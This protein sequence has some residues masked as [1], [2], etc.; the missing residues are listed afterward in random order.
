[1]QPLL[2]VLEQFLRGALNEGI[3]VGQ[4]R[5]LFRPDPPRTV[6]TKLNRGQP[7][8]HGLPPGQLRQ[9]GEAL[10]LRLGQALSGEAGQGG[11]FPPA[12]AN[13]HQQALSRH[14]H[15]A[16]KGQGLGKGQLVAIEGEC[17]QGFR[18]YLEK[19][20]RRFSLNA[21]RPS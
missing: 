13:A 5:R 10:G 14:L 1:M 20:G 21:L 3:G 11:Y 7:G 9:A 17:H 2:P 16:V 4:C 12:V 6:Q 15:L 19:S 18:L 8:G